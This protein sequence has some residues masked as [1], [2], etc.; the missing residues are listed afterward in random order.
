MR[1]LLTTLS[2][3]ALV[4]LS[5]VSAL[6]IWGVLAAIGWPP[7]PIVMNEALSLAPIHTTIDLFFLIAVGPTLGGIAP[8][9]IGFVFLILVHTAFMTLAVSLSLSAQDHVSTR[10][11]VEAAMGRVRSRFL[12]VLVVELGF[13]SVSIVII[14]LVQILG[15]IAFVV[16]LMATLFF[17]VFVPPAVIL[18]GI[19]PREALRASMALAR[20]TGSRQGLLVGGYV[21]FVLLMF[22]SPG[23][24][25]VATPSI[26]V[27]AFALLAGL[28][29]VVALSTFVHRWRVLS[30]ALFPE[31]SRG[32]RD[33]DAAE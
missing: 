3:P 32:H 1:G 11:A 27:W 19:A 24:A 9:L 31:S 16:G 10:E 23:R 30:P 13:I 25:G 15:T 5:F 6:L 14:F 20:M 28:I 29:H 2:S 7:Q 8:G 18:D 21:L 4:V 12:S 26:Q 22:F 33:D 17:S